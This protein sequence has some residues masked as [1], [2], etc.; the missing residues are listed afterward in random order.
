MEFDIDLSQFSKEL[1]E[2]LVNYPGEVD[3]NIDSS[4]GQE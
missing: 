4:Y 2:S 1:F 3:D